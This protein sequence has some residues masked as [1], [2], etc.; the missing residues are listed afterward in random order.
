MSDATHGEFHF[1]RGCFALSALLLA[2]WTLYWLLRTDASISHRVIVGMVIGAVVLAGF[3]ESLRW[4]ASRE[5]R[6]AAK[7]E[8]P[9]EAKALDVILLP[10][11]GQMNLYNNG[12]NDLR[13]YGDK[14]GDEPRDMVDAPRVIPSGAFY[15]FL[16]DKM[17]A[18]CRARLG[19]NGER[20]YPFECY[21]SDS[22]NKRYVAQFDLLVTLKDG[23]FAIHAQQ[24][25]VEEQDWKAASPIQASSDDGPSI[26]IESLRIVNLGAGKDSVVKMVI[27]NKGTT[28]KIV[29]WSANTVCLNAR[30]SNRPPVS[31][32]PNPDPVSNKLY[33]PSGETKELTSTMAANSFEPYW[34][35]IVKG[36]EFFYYYGV[37]DYKN[38]SDS[39]DGF[40]YELCFWSVYNPDFGTFSDAPFGNS[41]TRIMPPSSVPSTSIFPP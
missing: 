29:E 2:G 3:P 32:A 14:F 5:R 31:L 10:F 15:Y 35:G 6:I 25:G 39:S 37:I 21:L 4:V 38:I 20:L 27:A 8:V 7:Q 17:E 36:S 30:L 18:Y 23:V 12:S 34:A 13:L 41:V 22:S 11:A 9:P 33:I 24:L 40:Q 28:T 19:G 1:A 26:W 16:T